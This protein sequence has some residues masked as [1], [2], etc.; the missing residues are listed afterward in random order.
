M[1]D[2]KQKT[3]NK[4]TQ[5]AIRVESEVVGK[6]DN[7]AISMRKKTG[8]NVTRADIVR[9]AIDEYFENKSK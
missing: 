2:K 6:I 8:F 3:G 4:D 7:E 5:I 9:K 1:T